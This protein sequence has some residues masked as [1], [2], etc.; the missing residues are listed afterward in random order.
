MGKPLI[1]VDPLPRTLDVICDLETRRRLDDLGE[2]VICEDAPMA[3]AIVERH[4]RE[5]ELIIG[6]T[7]MTRDRLDRAPKLRA[8][9][10]IEELEAGR[11]GA[12]C[13]SVV[14]IGFNGAMDS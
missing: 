9:E 8:I 1:L 13:G 5:V 10:I 2:L 14:W 3:D 12:Y 6:Q 11:R 4:L 7:T